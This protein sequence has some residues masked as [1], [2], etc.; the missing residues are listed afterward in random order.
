MKAIIAA[1]GE[2][3]RMLPLTLEKPKPMLEVL[4][5]PLLAY[6]LESLPDEIDEV[7]MV[8]GYKREIIQNYFGESYQN[9]KITYIVQEKKTGTGD[10][11]LLC[12]PY[13]KEGERFLLSWAD[14]IYDKGSIE[15]CLTHEY[16]FL[17]VDA[18][19]PRR[20]G[21]VLLN[22]DGSIKELKEKPEHPKSNTIAPGIYIIDTSIFNYSPGV[23]HGENHLT[24]MLDQFI[25]NHKVFTERA[26]FWITI[27]FPDDLRVAEEKMKSRI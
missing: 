27:G 17:V 20:Y 15:R 14:D 12:K 21:V 16:C 22:D 8:V 4:G 19:D 3:K 24:P 6:I 7:L 1:A 23:I 26:H 13:L 11:V 5:K 18:E 25:R 10:A 2:G 9:K